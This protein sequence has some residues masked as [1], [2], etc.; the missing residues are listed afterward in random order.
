M[1]STVEARIK[2]VDYISDEFYGYLLA[3][4]PGGCDRTKDKALTVEWE[5]GSTTPKDLLPILVSPAHDHSPGDL[6]LR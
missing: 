3:L 4:F 2:V 1:T 5:Q 6:G